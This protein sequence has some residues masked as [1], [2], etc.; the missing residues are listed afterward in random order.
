MTLGEVEVEASREFEIVLQTRVWRWWSRNERCRW[1]PWLRSS[2]AQP[3]QVVRSWCRWSH[4]PLSISALSSNS[5][6]W[7]EG[8]VADIN[9]TIDSNPP[10]G[11]TYDLVRHVQMSARLINNNKQLNI[12]EASDLQLLVRSGNDH[13][14]LGANCPNTTR[15]WNFF[16]CWT[17]HLPKRLQCMAG[18][19][20]CHYAP[21]SPNSQLK[22]YRDT[23]TTTSASR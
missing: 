22:G 12:I 15:A 8:V 19:P 6:S 21:G 23:A 1:W 5:A 3:S 7:L 20:N 13:P 9:K 14:Y 18:V 16:S 4:Q 10:E 2:V 17:T 11:N